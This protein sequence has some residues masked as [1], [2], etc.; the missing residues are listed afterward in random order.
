MIIL[1]TQDLVSQDYIYYAFDN[2]K[3]DILID[4]VIE[5]TESSKL[6]NADY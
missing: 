1:Q 5:T 6:I 2:S 3:Q 4:S